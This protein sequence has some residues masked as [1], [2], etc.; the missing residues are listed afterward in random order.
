VYRKHSVGSADIEKGG[1]DTRA[2]IPVIAGLAESPKKVR[3]V[4][5][6]GDRSL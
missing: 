4:G 6:V 3:E 1:I 5:E 2:F